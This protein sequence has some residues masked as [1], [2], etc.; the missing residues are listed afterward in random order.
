VLVIDCVEL[1][2]VQELPGPGNFDH[3]A[4]VF[5]EPFV[6]AG[7]EIVKVADV[8]ESVRRND[9]LRRTKLVHQPFGGRGGKIT[10]FNID[11]SR[12][13][14]F[15]Q[16]GGRIDPDGAA[17][18][19]LAGCEEQPIIAAYVHNQAGVGLISQDRCKFGEVT[20]H[21]ISTGRHIQV[22]FEKT[23][24]HL[25]GDLDQPA[26]ETHLRVQRKCR[27]ALSDVRRAHEAVGRRMVSHRKE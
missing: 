24:R 23:F 16:I 5:G 11:S 1:V 6:H 21:P 20:V 13:G 8:V 15:G 26:F 3:E 27:L 18:K 10:D 12:P 14:N 9:H 7:H 19:F 17:A 25:V 2:L 22:V 4:T